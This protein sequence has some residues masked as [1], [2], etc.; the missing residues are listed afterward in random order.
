MTTT[1]TQTV[2]NTALQ[3]A[4]AVSAALAPTDPRLAAI[5]GVAPL[6]TQFLDAA[7]KIQQSGALT[8]DQLAALF[9]SVGQSVE[10]T[11]AQWDTMTEA[12]GRK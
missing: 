7:A 12:A 2:L 3:T 11:Q 5:V 8:P 6:I 10:Q 1:T 9:A 4:L